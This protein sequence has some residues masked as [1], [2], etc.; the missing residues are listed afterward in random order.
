MADLAELN[1]TGNTINLT[2]VIDNSGATLTL[3]AGSGSWHLA[4][5]RVNGG[6]VS[7][8]SGA[9][10]TATGTSTK[11]DP[12]FLDPPQKMAPKRIPAR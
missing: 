9:I 4:G 8:S 2:G 5:G 3:E 11:L 10:L 7:A 12:A 6:T 1:L